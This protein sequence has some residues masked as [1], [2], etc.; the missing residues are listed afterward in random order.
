VWDAIVDVANV[1]HSEDLDPLGTKGPYLSRLDAVVDAWRIAHGAGVRVELVAD[2]ALLH[3]LDPTDKRRL[4]RMASRREVSLIPVADTLV[5]ERAQESRLHVISGDRFL[6]F[7]RRHPWIEDHPERFHHWRQDA[8]GVRFVP[9]GIR[10]E[11]H[12]HVSRAEEIKELREKHLDP[13]LHLEI[14]NTRWRCQ[15]SVCL[16]ARMW[17]GQLPVWPRVDAGA[18]ALCPGCGGVLDPVGPRRTTRQVSLSSHTTGESIERVPL[19]LGTNLVLGRGSIANGY[20]L[21]SRQQR[22]GDAVRYVSRQHVLLRLEGGR[23]GERVAAVDL[24]SS[25]GTE[26]Q[27]WNGTA[28]EPGSPLTVDVEVVLT[29][30]DRLVLGGGVRVEV[31]GRRFNADDLP[32]VTGDGGGQVTRIRALD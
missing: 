9:R 23:S 3:A 22:F 11:H 17:A 13:R 1:C 24:G 8:D 4:A 31:S 16:Y 7:R 28:Y 2:K 12:R 30:Q 10:A 18:R 19:E 32:R 6:D 15:D 29:P 5:L 14:M 25:N 21:G 26:I 20:N 27:R